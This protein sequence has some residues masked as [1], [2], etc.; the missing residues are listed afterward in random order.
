[1]AKMAAIGRAILADFPCAD[2]GAD[3]RVPRMRGCTAVAWGLPRLPTDIVGAVVDKEWENTSQGSATIPTLERREAMQTRLFTQLPSLA[4]AVLFTMLVGSA[5][6]EP[7]K[8]EGTWDVTLTC[9]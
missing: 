4:L 8:L 7:S 2:K 9:P 6:A 1:M 5:A 3:A